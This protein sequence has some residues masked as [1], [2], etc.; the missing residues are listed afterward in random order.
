MSFSI[1]IIFL[2]FIFL[3]YF[4]FYDFYYFFIISI[5]RKSCWRYPYR[6]D[7]PARSE[8]VKEE[9]ERL[10]TFSIKMS[11]FSFSSFTHN[12]NKNEIKRLIGF[13]SLS[14]KE[15][16]E[17]LKKDTNKKKKKNEKSHPEIQHAHLF[18][19]EKKRKE[20]K[21]KKNETYFILFLK[22]INK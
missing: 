3:F 15:R 19:K 21:R 18:E 8:G 9:E 12:S 2:F 11:S 13:V 4:I 5:E 17:W 20:K 14:A 6:L 10:Q 16:R 7:W 22:I 1:L